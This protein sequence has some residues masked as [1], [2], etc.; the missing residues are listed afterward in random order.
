VRDSPSL[1]GQSKRSRPEAVLGHRPSR[2]GRRPPRPFGSCC[3][4]P[5][6]C[7][8]TSST[9]LAGSER[10]GGRRGRTRRSIGGD[11]AAVSEARRRLS[12]RWRERVPASAPA[13]R[14]GRNPLAHVTRQAASTTRSRAASRRRRRARPK[15]AAGP[16]RRVR[17]Q[18]DL[19]RSAARRRG[20]R[21]LVASIGG[22]AGRRRR[23]GRGWPQLPH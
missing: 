9:P 13:S 12:G 4:R 5:R 10:G 19:S 17:A 6:R 7:P 21:A 8:R 23:L 11:R 1:A 2:P 14:G 22:A 3:G 15:V 16:D 20:L 18:F